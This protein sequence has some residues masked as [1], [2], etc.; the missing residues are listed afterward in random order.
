MHR[1]TRHLN[2][3]SAG[4]V[5]ALDARFLKLS[6]GAAITS[7]TNR[8]GT[9]NLT[10]A[11]AANQ[12]TFKTAIQG[13]SPVVRFDASNDFLSIG[14]SINFK[15]KFTFIVALKNNSL[16][17]LTIFA[18]ETGDIDFVLWGGLGLGIS[19]SGIAWLVNQGS[20]SDTAWKI[21]S[22]NFNGTNT[23]SIYRD[24]VMVNTNTSVNQILTN[25]T[26]FYVGRQSGG[27]YFDGDMGIV[28]AIQS[29]ISDSLR[30][31]LERCLAL[32]YKI[33][34]N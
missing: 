2:P 10:Q 21:V 1:R 26:T 29:Y 14:G 20:S 34:C 6:D 13:G 7:W 32:T 18:K 31:R 12:P 19:N 4:A 5:V 23:A 3:S 9:N 16:N 33:K 27:G 25:T 8:T 24:S 11:T 15:D 17:N 28:I 22:G 30:K